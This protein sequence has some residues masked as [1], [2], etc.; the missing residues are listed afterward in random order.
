M[1]CCVFN[2][3][4]L[5]LC[6]FQDTLVPGITWVLYTV[7]PSPAFN[8]YL[9]LFIFFGSLCLAVEINAMKTP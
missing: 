3:L 9:F 2:R 8:F 5:L 6:N 1:T 7:V 4:L